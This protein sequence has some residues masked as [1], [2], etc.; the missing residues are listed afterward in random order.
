MQQLGHAEW[1][2]RVR[3]YSFDMLAAWFTLP[4]VLAAPAWEVPV[5]EPGASVVVTAMT[6]LSRIATAASAPAVLTAALHCLPGR[7]RTNES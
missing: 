7:R 5:K 1:L 4:L 6:P 2:H 3:I